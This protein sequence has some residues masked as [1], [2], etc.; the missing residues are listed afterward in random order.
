MQ[1]EIHEQFKSL[2]K[3]QAWASQHQREVFS[4]EHSEMLIEYIRKHGTEDPLTA[5]AY[6][7]KQVVISHDNY[8]ETIKSGPLISRHRAMLLELQRVAKKGMGHLVNRRC[9]IY[10]PEGLTDFA[11]Y[12]RGIYPKFIGSEFAQTDDERRALFPIPSEDLQALSFPN[13]TFDL[14]LS[15]DVFEH[16][17][18][19]DQAL[20]EMSRVL[21]DAGVLIANFPFLF[22]RDEGI[23]KAKLVRGKLKHLTEPEYHGNPMRPDEGSLVFE[24]PAW[25][26][27]AR[28]KNAGFEDAYFS[29][30]SSAKYGVVGKGINGVFVFVASKKKNPGN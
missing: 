1:T 27:V 6:P 18:D 8:R 25:D 23:V 29:Y 19:L 4:K 17:P 15:N 22:Q 21:N 11:L 5:T 30:V 14:V 3:W 16:L 2:A 9:K 20:R 26:I 24:L 12:L 10:A 7:S 13:D 28:A